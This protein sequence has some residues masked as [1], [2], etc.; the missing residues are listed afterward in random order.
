LAVPLES[1]KPLLDENLS[2]RFPSFAGAKGATHKEAARF[3]DHFP[4]QPDA[5]HVHPLFGPLGAEEWQRSLFKH[6]YH[7][8]LQSGLINK[9]GKPND[10]HHSS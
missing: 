1:K 6:C 10:F 4:E 9:Q 7:H 5:I 2:F 8:L 3:A